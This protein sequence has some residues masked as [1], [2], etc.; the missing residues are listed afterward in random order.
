MKKGYGGEK[1]KKVFYASEKKGI[2]GSG[3]WTM[4]KDLKSRSTKKKAV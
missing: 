3:G 4:K 1:G 2:Q